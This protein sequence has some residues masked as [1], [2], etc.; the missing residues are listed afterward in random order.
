ML[1]EKKKME[2]SSFVNKLSGEALQFALLT[3]Y[4]L[5]VSITL[6]L[7]KSEV[8]LKIARLNF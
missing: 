4:I 1:P 3:L 6:L 8:Y 2:K 7:Q 5:K